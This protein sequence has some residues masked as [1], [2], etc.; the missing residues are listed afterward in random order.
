MEAWALADL[1][2]STHRHQEAL[3]NKWYPLKLPQDAYEHHD[4]FLRIGRNPSNTNFLH[5]DKGKQVRK[6]ILMVTTGSKELLTC[7]P[8]RG[9]GSLVHSIDPP[10]NVSL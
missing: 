7:R 10:A 9:Y 5:H 1:T 3:L 2:N 6:F 8:L 4:V